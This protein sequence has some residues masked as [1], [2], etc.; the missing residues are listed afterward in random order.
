MQAIAGSALAMTFSMAL[1]KASACLS[2]SSSPRATPGAPASSSVAK[3]PPRKRIVI[4]FAVARSTI[5]LLYLGR[6][7]EA[8]GKAAQPAWRRTMTTPK[9]LNNA[10][11]GRGEAAHTW[12][13]FCNLSGLLIYEAPF[14]PRV[15][16]FAAT[17]GYVIRPLRAPTG[18]LIG[19][20]NR[21]TTIVNRRSFRPR[22]LCARLPLH[23]TARSSASRPPGYIRAARSPD[24][25]TRAADTF[26]DAIKPHPRFWP[27]VRH[28]RNRPASRS[29]HA[30]SLR[31]RAAWRKPAQL[32]H[33]TSH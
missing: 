20:G 25:Q 4:P 17:L 2:G 11:Q 26:V 32:R 22:P 29:S 23:T 5:L 19:G 3:N 30:R 9:A 6:A 28:R 12:A 15:R 13:R 8:T 10:A 7:A 31:G 18:W 27:I 21:H 14:F 16:R 1:C 24:R 33:R